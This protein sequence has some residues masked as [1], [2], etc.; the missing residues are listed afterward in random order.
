[1]FNKNSLSQLEKDMLVEDILGEWGQFIATTEDL[2]FLAELSTGK[3][4][5]KVRDKWF[6]KRENKD[7]CTYAIAQGILA[8]V[9]GEDPP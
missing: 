1:M 2:F 5:R 9:Y 6:N 7:S 3:M 8:D 4:K